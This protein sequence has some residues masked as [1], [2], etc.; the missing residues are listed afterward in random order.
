MDEKNGS[1]NTLIYLLA[2]EDEASRKAGFD[3][4]RKDPDWQSARQA[5]EANGKL[6]VE[7]GVTAVL[8]MPT[9]YSPTK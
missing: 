4:F 2:H 9:D 7:Q 6:L 1:K 5:S 3:A 8:L